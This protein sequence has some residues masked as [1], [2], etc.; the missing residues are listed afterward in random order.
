M[1]QERSAESWQGFVNPCLSHV[2]GL[3]GVF[4]QVL[5]TADFD[6]SKSGSLRMDLGVRLRLILLFDIDTASK[7]RDKLHDPVYH[8]GLSHPVAFTVSILPSTCR[9]LIRRSFL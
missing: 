2:P 9:L 4:Q 5:R 3:G 1:P 7:C 6:C 8:L